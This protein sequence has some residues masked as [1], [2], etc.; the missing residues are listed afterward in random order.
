MFTIQSEHF[1][2]ALYLLLN[3]AMDHVHGIFQ[4]KGTS[5]FETLDGTNASETSLTSHSQ[6]YIIF[7]S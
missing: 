7:S 3:E 4:D 1:T 2:K 6:S 5:L